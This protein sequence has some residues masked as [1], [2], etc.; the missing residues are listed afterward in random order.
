MS[1]R[2][3]LFVA[4]GTL[5]ATL[6][7]LG[8]VLYFDN[9][10]DKVGV[11]FEPTM[12]AAEEDLE[13]FWS[14]LLGDLGYGDAYQGPTVHYFSPTEVEST[15]CGDTLPNQ[16]FFCGQ[17]RTI[18]IDSVM[19]EGMFTNSGAY[20]AVFVLSHEWGHA[21]QHSLGI[22][23]SAAFNIQLGLQADCFAGMYSRDL[24]ERDL[25]TDDDLREAAGA[26]ILAADPEAL[27][28]WAPSAQGDPQQRV[29]AFTAGYDE[30]W[31]AC[32]RDPFLG[33]QVEPKSE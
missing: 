19:L 7:F 27:P 8:L 18:Y 22:L 24:D 17:D 26:L 14:S 2:N 5:V 32:T 31:P 30:G 9:E 25:I 10:A 21:V 12:E 11:E 13:A 16:A 15:S 20:A 3:W 23:Q 33:P 6:V 29:A 28:W 1:D 4:S